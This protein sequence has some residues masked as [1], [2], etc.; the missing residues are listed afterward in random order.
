MFQTAIYTIFMIVAIIFMIY[1]ITDKILY[2]LKIRKAEKTLEEGIS[3][4]FESFNG[5]TV[6]EKINQKTDKFISDLGKEFKKSMIELDK[7]VP[8]LK[9]GLEYIE[10]NYLDRFEC[11]WVNE[12]KPLLDSELQVTYKVKEKKPKK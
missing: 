7:K 10:T 5:D 3:K 6:M 9:E 12:V 1:M 2:K 4:F 8:N 11:W